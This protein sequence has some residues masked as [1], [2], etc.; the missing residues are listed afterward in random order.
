MKTLGQHFLE[1]QFLGQ[2][3]LGQWLIDIWQL[4]ESP[5]WISSQV[6]DFLQEYR[7]P[8]HSHG[9]GRLTHHSNI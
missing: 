3:F 2:Q 4:Q 9:P 5:K 8:H 6:D 7:K 1:Q